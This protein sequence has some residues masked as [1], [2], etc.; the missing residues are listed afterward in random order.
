M[1]V[2]GLTGLSGAG[3]TTVAD[4]LVRARG[5]TRLSFREPVKAMLRSLDPYLG[6]DRDFSTRPRLSE[7]LAKYTEEEIK[8]SPF[9]AEYVRLLEALAGAHPPLY[10]V[11]TAIEM[12]SDD[13]G[14]YVFDDVRFLH[15]ARVI[16]DLNPWGLWQIVRPEME[17]ADAEQNAGHLGEVQTLF[18]VTTKE[19]LYSEADRAL[20]LA[21]SD[22][23]PLAEAS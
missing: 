8:A 1:N 13:D 5:Y 14:L 21:F 4:Y 18:N 9:G 22:T 23:A 12:V 11:N 7:L 10:W 16:K 19:F 3:K 15:E 17:T 2:V 6:Y 20:R